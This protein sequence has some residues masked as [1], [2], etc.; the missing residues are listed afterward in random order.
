MMRESDAI[1][2]AIRAHPEGITTAG[3]VLAVH[4]DVPPY[5][6]TTLVYNTYCKASRLVKFGLVSKEL[7]RLPAREGHQVQAVWRPIA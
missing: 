3:I 7:A 4:P 5:R 1:L 6:V 2:E